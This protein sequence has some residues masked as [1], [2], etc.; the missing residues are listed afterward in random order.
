MLTLEDVHDIIKHKVDV[1]ELI[2]LLQISTDDIL[3]RFD[4]RLELYM[5]KVLEAIE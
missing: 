4:D 1:V 2:E 5:T 3:D